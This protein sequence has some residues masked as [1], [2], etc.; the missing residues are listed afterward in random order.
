MWKQLVYI[1]CARAN[2]SSIISENISK[3]ITTHELGVLINVTYNI[4]NT[5]G[6][7]VVSYGLNLLTR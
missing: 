4:M 1:L 3:H 2:S 7:G 6:V 5:T